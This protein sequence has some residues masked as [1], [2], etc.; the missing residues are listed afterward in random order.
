MDAT[1]KEKPLHLYFQSDLSMPN[2]A[3]PEGIESTHHRIRIG[4]AN[5]QKKVTLFHYIPSISQ[6][7]R[8]S[9]GPGSLNTT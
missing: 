2:K 1:V 7:A 6:Q 8:I 4:A 5:T 3:A 9:D